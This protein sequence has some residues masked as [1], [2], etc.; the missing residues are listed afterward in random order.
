MFWVNN[1]SLEDFE[2]TLICIQLFLF[3]ANENLFLGNPLISLW[4]SFRSFSDLDQSNNWFF[5]I[6]YTL[7]RLQVHHKLF[8]DFHKLRSSLSFFS[9]RSK[10]L[11]LVEDI[12]RSN[13][14]DDYWTCLFLEK[15]EKKSLN[16]IHKFTFYLEVKFCF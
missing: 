2:L 12:T 13:D 10:I 6:L 1:K 15:K 5:V 11:S 8:K 16:F 9:F 3:H 7:A 4:M 14:Q